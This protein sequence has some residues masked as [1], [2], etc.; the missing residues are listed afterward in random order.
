MPI[1]QLDKL[2]NYLTCSQNHVVA[3]LRDHLT[4]IHLKMDICIQDKQV[5]GGARFYQYRSLN[6]PELDSLKKGKV[7]KDES[8][9]FSD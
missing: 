2:I 1:L 8:N 4:M 6:S 7:G 9:S 5:F 3:T